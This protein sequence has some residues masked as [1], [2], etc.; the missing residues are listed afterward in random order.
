MEYSFSVLLSLTSSAYYCRWSRLLYRITLNDTHTHTLGE[1]PL[2]EGSARR[3]GLYLHNTQHLQQTNVHASSGMR[4][5]ST[6]KRAAAG[7]C[8]RSCNHRDQANLF[9]IMEINDSHVH[10]FQWIR[11]L[12]INERKFMGTTGKR[13][14]VYKLTNH[15]RNENMHT[16][17]I[18]I[19]TQYRTN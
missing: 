9:W 7:L 4:N 18:N 2:E 16:K 3:R 5:R 10:A 19:P 1:I 13:K 12:D 17:K 11:M 6:S 8:I 15:K 14:C